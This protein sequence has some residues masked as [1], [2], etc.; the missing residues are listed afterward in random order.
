MTYLEFL[1]EIVDQ[2]FKQIKGSI[3]LEVP[4]RCF[5]EPKYP[6]QAV[7]KIAFNKCDFFVN[8]DC[9][10]DSEFGDYYL[11]LCKSNFKDKDSCIDYCVAR[12]CIYVSNEIVSCF[13]EDL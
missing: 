12:L 3:K 11:A 2:F 1:E 6:K 7:I 10:I 13:L 4:I 9:G 8:L 5:D